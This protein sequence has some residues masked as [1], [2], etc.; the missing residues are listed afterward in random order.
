M[1]NPEISDQEIG[2]ITNNEWKVSNSRGTRV[3]ISQSTD[4]ITK[5]NVDDYINAAIDFKLNEF[6]LQVD[7]IREGL[8]CFIK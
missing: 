3:R 5:E 6:K 4:M 2:I 7:W 8:K 1:R